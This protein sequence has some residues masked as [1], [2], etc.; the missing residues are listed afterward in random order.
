MNPFI[1]ATRRNP[2]EPDSPAEEIYVNTGAV[3]YMTDNPEGGTLIHLLNEDMP[4]QVQ[5]SC[6][7]LVRRLRPTDDA[8]AL[9]LPAETE[10]VERSPS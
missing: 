6:E 2:Q 1:R 4:M 7:E 5:E 9:P 8:N 10:P 3:Q